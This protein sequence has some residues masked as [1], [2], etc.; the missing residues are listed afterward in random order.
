[1]QNA[2]KDACNLK[3][4]QYNKGEKPNRTSA[5]IFWK[6]GE[7]MH[8]KR[9]LRLVSAVLALCMMAA[10][11]PTAAFATTAAGQT[12]EYAGLKYTVNEGGTTVSVAKQGENAVSG[13]VVIPATVNDSAGTKYPVTSIGNKA[14]CD[15][16]NLTSVEI[17][18]GVTSIGDRAF[19]NCSALKNVEI[20]SGVTSIGISAFYWC[21]RLTDVTF[22]ANSR[23]TSIGD[24][25]FVNGAMKEL[26]IP[27]GVQTIGNWVFLECGDL[28]T[29]TIPDSVTSVG[30]YIFDFGAYKKAKTIIY[31]GAEEQWKKLG[32]NLPEGSTVQYKSHT[33]QFDPNGHGT[34]PENIHV[35]NGKTIPADKKPADPTETGYTFKNWYYTE[36]GVEK[37]FE[38]G[39]NGTKVTSSMT[40]KAKWEINQYTVTFNPNGGSGETI[41]ETVQHGEKVTAP[42]DPKIEGYI[43]DGWHEY[44]NGTGEKFDPNRPVTETKVYY[45]HWVDKYDLKPDYFTFMPPE[46]LVYNGEEKAATVKAKEDGIGEIRIKYY[47]DNAEVFPIDPGT[48]TVKINVEEGAEYK[49]ETG[50][51][52]ETWKFTITK[53]TPQASMF[54]F[55]A[56]SGL[57]YDGQPK[58]AV[59]TARSGDAVGSVTVK[60]YKEDDTVGTTA[61]PTEPGT[62]A[63]KIDV[64]DTGTLYGKATDLT[65][66]NWSFTITKADLTPTNLQLNRETQK[67]ELAEGVKGAGEIV[68]RWYAVENGQPTGEPRMTLDGAKAGL[69]QAEA[70]IAEGSNYEAVTLTDP[71]WQIFVAA[72][73]E[74][75]KPIFYDITVKN[76]TTNVASAKKGDLIKLFADEAPEGEAFDYWKVNGAKIEGD[77]FEMPAEN[78]TAEAVYK[79][80]TYTVIF[81][82]DHDNTPNSLTVKHGETILGD[83]V[84]K[85][86]GYEF[87]GWYNGREKFVF[88]ENGT[89]VTANLTL[90]AQWTEVKKPEPKPVVYEIVVDN[91]T[92]YLDDGATAIHTAEEGQTVILKVNPEALTEGFAFDQ[93]EVVSGEV[94]LADA[95]AS[96]TSFEMPASDVELKATVKPIEPAAEPLTGLEQAA[97]LT[98]GTV[99]AGA[100]VAAV[101]FAAYGIGV[102]LYAQALLPAG[103]ALPTN[104]GELAVLVWNMAGKPQPALPAEGL[105]DAQTALLWAAESGLLP[106]Q[107]GTTPEDPEL[108]VSARE[109]VRA[110]RKARSLAPKG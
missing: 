83:R 60:Y 84:L 23:L 110:L 101:G 6:E 94:K 90:T 80:K 35:E 100:G 86:D 61:I 28:Q 18:S 55:T 97:L 11:L 8:K 96:E 19:F 45:A 36:N 46:I 57:T 107:A 69:Y 51:T 30:N 10:L 31:G 64:D 38:F 66:D 56:P 20:P 14:F 67:M 62:Y 106:A 68:T 91:G 43:F 15:C 25:A 2:Q 98:T 3:K 37:A 48:Y 103:A 70:V 26:V 29:V 12:F 104:C 73:L 78:V 13:E 47:N 92:A 39:E 24:S 16:Y 89:K 65:A 41:K 44:P 75:G 21:D 71:G 95:T 105:T 82:T 5:D 58:E 50:L 59:V 109:V 42:E 27:E 22:E 34:A 49:G 99:V 9:F 87:G 4:F 102:E 79:A 52:S 7:L 81:V 76:G 74:P 1:M 93:W 85:A 33:V 72:T 53:G 40:L 32:V 17:P 63:V 54:D 88:G 108:P 77:S